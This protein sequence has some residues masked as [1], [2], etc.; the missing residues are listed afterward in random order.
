MTD[1]ITIH[2]RY[3]IDPYKIQQFEHY[4]QRWIT[5]VNRFGGVH[6]GYFMP[7]EGTSNVA[8]ALFSFESMEAYE[9]YRT[10]AAADADC[11]EVMAYEAEHRSIASYERTF[12]RPVVDGA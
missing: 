2:L 1:V 12:L 8:Y 4:A 10:L 3:I 9:Q 6:H 7:S 5:L 11:Q